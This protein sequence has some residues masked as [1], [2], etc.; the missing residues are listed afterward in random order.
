MF[1]DGQQMLGTMA[2]GRG[3]VTGG[4][5]GSWHVLVRLLVAVGFGPELLL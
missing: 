5:L 1:G 3:T 2:M 4:L